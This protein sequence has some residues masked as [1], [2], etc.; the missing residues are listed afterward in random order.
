MIWNSTIY[1]TLVT[2]ASRLPNACLALGSTLLLSACAAAQPA[3]SGTPEPAVPA[4]AIRVN[5]QLYML[6]MG[7]DDTGC[8][9]FQP[10]SPTLMVVQALHW[11]AADGS[12]TLDRHA[13]DCP[14]PAGADA[15]AQN[16]SR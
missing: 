6:P 4:G 15:A 16:G 7:T 14:P 1:S 11:R 13:A 2:A 9:M 12:F 5:D 10:W 8:P 3:D